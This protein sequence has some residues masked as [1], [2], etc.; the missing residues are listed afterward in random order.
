RLQR[1]SFVAKVVRAKKVNCIC[2]DIIKLNRK[3]DED[4]INQYANGPG[5]KQKKQK[6]ILCF[7]NSTDKVVEEE[8][9]VEDVM[10]DDDIITVN[11]NKDEINREENANIEIINLVTNQT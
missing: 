2:G 11:E 5:Y 8:S 9:E 1:N 7:F 10:D 3:Y 6:S 4:Y